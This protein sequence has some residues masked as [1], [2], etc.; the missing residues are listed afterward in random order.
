[1][2]RIVK[3]AS[4]AAAACFTQIAFSQQVPDYGL[5]WR[6]VGSPGNAAF[7]G[8]PGNQL[9]GYGAVDHS[10]R[11]TATEVTNSTWAEFCN[12]YAPFYQ[13]DP[14]STALSGTGVYSVPGPGGLPVFQAFAGLENAP[15]G[16]SWR[17][18][19]RY[20]NWLASGQAHEAAAFERGAY[21]TS[22]F[23]SSPGGGWTDQR[24]HDPSASIWIPSIDEWL[25]AAYFD[26]NHGGPNSPGWWTYPNSS[27]TPPLPGFPG[28]GET[29][30]S[31]GWLDPTLGEAGQY[32]STQ[33]PWG[34]LD[35]SGG[36]R[37]MTEG[38]QWRV[39][40]SDLLTQPEFSQ[41]ED[42]IG[43]HGPMFPTFF[44]GFRVASA[45]P[46]PS[47]MCVLAGILLFRRRR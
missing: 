18:A 41:F 8:P 46:A 28:V 23:G 38:P 4:T 14:Y 34:L 42:A 36:F 22:T 7:Q 27:D 37:E 3:L 6:T 32:P 9:S 19:A 2:A 35:L 31:M 33:S 47:S 45:I 20:V 15:A 44:Y 25:K 16:V 10:F 1:M 21:D 11:L 39:L 24:I 12:A 30:A 26:P 40:G 17:M 13:G 43:Y 29:N 5:Q